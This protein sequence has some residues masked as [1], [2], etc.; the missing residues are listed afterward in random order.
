[1][2]IE[3]EKGIVQHEAFDSEDSPTGHGHAERKETPLVQQ[4][5]AVDPDLDEHHC[6]SIL[7]KMDTRIIPMVTVLYLL[8]FL[9]RG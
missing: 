1:M 4:L 2:A 7:R 3:N 8:S 9:D 6:K 5:S